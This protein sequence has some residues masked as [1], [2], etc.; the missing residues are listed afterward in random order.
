[1]SAHNKRQ[2]TAPSALVSQQVARRLGECYFFFNVVKR[3]LF[4][5]V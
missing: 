3:S 4:W 1:M 2:H 5:A